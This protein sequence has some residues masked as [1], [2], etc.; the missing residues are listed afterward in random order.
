M[1]DRDVSPD[2]PGNG[3]ADHARVSHAVA[4][5]LRT[6]RAA[7]SWSLDRLAQ[8]SGVSKG[9]LVAL[10]AERGNPSLTTLCRLADAFS[11]SLTDLVEVHRKPELRHATLDGATTLWRGPNGGTGRLILSTDPP[12]AVELWWWRLE[13]GEARHSEAH[14]S[15]TREALLVIA[16]EV[17]V[18]TDNR[19]LTASAG[20]ALTW[21]GD[22]PHAYRNDTDQPAELVLIVTVPG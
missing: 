10:E 8:R 14:A 13:P 22:K 6:L 5:N 15:D 2:P 21:P 11:V 18:H 3:A 7:R 1:T 17:T 4:T 19:T 20:G 9:V 12:G 16:G